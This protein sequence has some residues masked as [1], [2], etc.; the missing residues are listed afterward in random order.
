[1]VLFRRVR[2]LGVSLVASVL[3]VAT[4]VNAQGGVRA[5]FWDYEFVDRSW[6]GAYGLGYDH[7]MNERLSM[8]FQVKYAEPFI[9]ADYRSAF[10]FSD[11]DHGSLYLGPQV[12]LRSFMSEEAMVFPV[13]F[14]TGVRG[15]LRG[16]YADLFAS[17]S[18]SLGE[19]A[20]YERDPSLTIPAVNGSP[21]SF[22]L[23]LHM[24][25]GWDRADR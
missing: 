10:H 9:Q 4:T 1:M 17:V 20:G 24:G 23:G 14:R 21:L 6:L 2:T 8:G 19:R 11:N 18:Y 16:F 12:G 3:M 25:I 5:I 7:D 22:N 15:G 13:G